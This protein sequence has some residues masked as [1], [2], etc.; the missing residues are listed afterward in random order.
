M[1]RLNLKLLK[2]KLNQILA[3][4]PVVFAYIFGS[5]AKGKAGPLSDLDVAIFIDKKL[6][7]RKMD[8]IRF[9]IKD[10]IEKVFKLQDKVDVAILNE[11][12]PLLE[13]EVVYDGKLIYVKDNGIR[14]HYEA[15]AIGRW[16]DWRFYEEQFLTAIKNRFGQP[17]KAT[18]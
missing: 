15:D 18:A 8:E 7:S 13:R 2:Q 17:I 5:C 16:L 11:A 3:G 9:N 6:S 12:P 10:E 14:A 1:K 4:Q